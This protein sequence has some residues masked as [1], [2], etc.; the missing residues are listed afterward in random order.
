MKPFSKPESLKVLVVRSVPLT[1]TEVEMALRV[2]EHT[3]WWLAL[4]QLIESQRI[5]LSEAGQH[6]ALA[7]NALAMAANCGAH[8]AL[9][10]ILSD[11][12]DRRAS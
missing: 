3:Q 7:N 9:T 10:A 1:D 11:L 6:C 5:E 2:S 8:T 12:E 4:T